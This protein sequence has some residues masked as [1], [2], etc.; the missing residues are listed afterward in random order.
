M[1]IS[2]YVHIKKEAKPNIVN[3]VLPNKKVILAAGPIYN[4]IIRDN[5]SVRS[6]SNRKE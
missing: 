1:N 5:Q 2:D 3:I 4:K 6:Q